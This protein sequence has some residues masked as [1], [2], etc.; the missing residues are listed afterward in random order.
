MEFILK[1]SCVSY[2]NVK[3]ELSG[4]HN[5]DEITNHCIYCGRWERADYDSIR[6]YWDAQEA[7]RH[8]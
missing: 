4:E 1:H 2:D 6:E 8:K 7:G 3:E 5:Y